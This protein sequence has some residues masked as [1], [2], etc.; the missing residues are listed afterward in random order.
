MT[1]TFKS[2]QQS[3][4]SDCT[5]LLNNAQWLKTPETRCSDAQCCM[6]EELIADGA[7]LFIRPL[8]VFMFYTPFRNSRHLHQHSFHSDNFIFPVHPLALSSVFFKFSVIF[9]GC[10]IFKLSSS[11]VFLLTF[12]Q[13]CVDEAAHL[14]WSKFA[15]Q[16]EGDSRLPFYPSFQ[17]HNVEQRKRS[18]KHRS[19]S[20]VFLILALCNYTHLFWD[21]FVFQ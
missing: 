1:V 11:R 18:D 2:P 6:H 4:S 13:F 3:I 10:V 20:V 5:A 19:N 9:A 17:Y 12:C 15:E 7:T 14:A 8:H 16:A 21:M